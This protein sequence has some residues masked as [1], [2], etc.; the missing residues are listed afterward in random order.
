L[1][2]FLA[3]CLSWTS[4]NARGA[5]EDPETLIRQ[6]VELR[7]KGEDAR[8]EG[9]L[10]RAY[11][12]AATPRTAAQLGLVELAVK[13]YLEADAH[14]GEALRT[15][16]SWVEENRHMLEDCRSSARKHLLRVELTSAPKGTV[17]AVEGAAAE[18]LPADGVVW[19]APGVTTTLQL[20]APGFKSAKIRVAGAAG[21]SRR[22]ALDMPALVEPPKAAAA[23]TQPAPVQPAPAVFAPEQPAAE[24]APA[25][26]PPTA[27]PATPDGPP[28][29]GR[30]LRIAG[31][32]IV[33]VG[34]AV[35]VVGGVVLAK[36]LSKRDELS[37]AINSHLT[38]PYNPADRNW[39]TW[40]DAGVACL[41]G[42]GVAVA[43][44]VGLYLLGRR[45]P[46]EEGAH[47]AFVPGPGFGVLSYGGN[48]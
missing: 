8:A 46:S 26:A 36:G 40:R 19:L 38:I 6:G 10:L 11:Q 7:R 2:S 4:F 3:A 23:P 47:V 16:D 30:G 29:P 13:K 22:V 18:T 41:V 35:S 27:T 21:A 12:L 31:L 25:E 48:F 5:G 17:F 20:D 44:G 42:G 14:L 32:T 43:G 45:A 37:T 28:V 39:E 9:Y 1:V 24:T 33:G 34:V 15:R